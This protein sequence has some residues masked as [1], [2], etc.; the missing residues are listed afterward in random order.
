[1]E[2]STI[3]FSLIVIAIMAF[4]FGTGFGFFMRTDNN[5][6]IVQGQPATELISLLSSNPVS[7]IMIY[8]TVEDIN[9]KNVVI[10]NQEENI[11]LEIES[12][13]KVYKADS[14]KTEEVKFEDIKKGDAL[15]I[16]SAITSDGKL[17]GGAIYIFSAIQ[18]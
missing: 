10:S 17:K 16:N 13:A 12:S 2:N 15:T 3:Y 9:G 4:V 1:M 5:I 8:G 11:S 18:Q 14:E 7:A 6:N